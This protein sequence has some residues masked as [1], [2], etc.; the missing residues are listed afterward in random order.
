MVGALVSVTQAV[1][2]PF[3]S[4]DINGAN[5]GGG[6]TLGP[7]EAGFQGWTAYQGFDPF[8]PAYMVDEDFGGS[9]TAGLTKVFSTSEGDITVNMAGGGAG[10]PIARNRGDGGGPFG[11]MYGDIAFMTRSLDGFGQNW[12]ALDI[13]GLVPGQVYLFTG[14]AEEPFNGSNADNNASFQAWT[15][16]DTLGGLDGPGLWMDANV[17]AGAVY[18]PVYESDVDTGYK[19][20]I[21]TIVR[22][23]I[24]GPQATS[25]FQYAA[26]F[27][28]TAD[29]GGSVSV[30]TW[31]DPQSY[32]GTQ[33]ATA[34]NGFQLEAV[35]EPA[36][37][38]LLAVGLFGLV[39][40]RRRVS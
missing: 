24:S 17:G 32:S 28:T 40:L 34:L 8:D 12:M 19:N 38:A 31:A 4:V 10:S 15:D 25:D 35:P 39:G 6:E 14:Y 7:T 1:A 22:T 16:I 29:G 27:R 26:R 36:S 33:T 13:S 3:L 30:Y 5:V 23:P 18:Q 2:D 9:G 20:P 37:L 11:A 21:P